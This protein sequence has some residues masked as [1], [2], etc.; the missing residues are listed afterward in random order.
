MTITEIKSLIESKL[1]EAAKPFWFSQELQNE[2][3]VIAQR[4]GVEKA[5]EEIEAFAKG[6]A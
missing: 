4:D 5:C 1:S 6:D 3:I 2:W